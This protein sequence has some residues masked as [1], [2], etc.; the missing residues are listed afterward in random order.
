MAGRGAQVRAASA[1]MARADGN[2]RHERRWLRRA[3]DGPGITGRGE[4]AGASPPDIGMLMAAHVAP[5][6]TRWPGGPVCFVDRRL[7]PA[8][9]CGTRLVP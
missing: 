3:P 4:A 8:R 2:R 1:R 7:V 9:Y 5:S 6:P